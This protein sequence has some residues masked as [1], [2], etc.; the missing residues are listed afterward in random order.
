MPIPT[1][2]AGR[3]VTPPLA[4]NFTNWGT[5]AA[6]NFTTWGTTPK[7]AT[8]APKPK[9]KPST[10]AVSR[11]ITAN[12]TS[13]SK[14]TAPKSTAPKSTTPTVSK[15]K[16]TTPAPVAKPAAPATPA[17]PALPSFDEWAM[18]DAEYQQALASYNLQL[19]NAQ[20]NRDTD[21]AAANQDQTNQLSDWQ[22]QFD[23]GQ[24]GLLDDFAARGLGNSGLFVQARDQY[25]SDAEAQKQALMDAILRRIQGADTS[26]TGEKTKAQDYLQQQKLL[27][28]QRGAGQFSGTV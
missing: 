27:A 2:D 26:L 16:P 19:A 10:G 15:P 11:R 24:Q 21:I 6:G 20:N 5:G 13:N 4:N 7:P 17:T 12:T 8:P 9:P 3:G 18:K 23:R 25:V 14:S 22:T 1:S 28:A